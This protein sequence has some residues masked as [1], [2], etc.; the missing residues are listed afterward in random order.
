MKLLRLN[1]SFYTYVGSVKRFV[2]IKLTQ[3][4]EVCT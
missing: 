1:F 4:K 3:I 2:V